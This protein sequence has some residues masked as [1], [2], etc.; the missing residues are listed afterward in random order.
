M[1]KW[2]KKEIAACCAQLDSYWLTRDVVSDVR[3][4]TEIVLSG[5]RVTRERYVARYR[6]E[7][8]TIGNQL[9][10]FTE[11]GKPDEL[12]ERFIG[13][14]R[15]TDRCHRMVEALVLRVHHEG[16]PPEVV[17]YDPTVRR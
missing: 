11:Y 10:R 12:I 8:E 16:L 15:E 1:S 9:V 17:D 3:A 13:L 4:R 6:Q 7:C 14:A 5:L 2:T